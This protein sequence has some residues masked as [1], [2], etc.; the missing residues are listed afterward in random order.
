MAGWYSLCGT[1]CFALSTGSSLTWKAGKPV[2][3]AQVCG[4]LLHLLRAVLQ[5]WSSCVP[6]LTCGM[7]SSRNLPRPQNL[8]AWQPEWRWLNQA[9]RTPRTQ[10]INTLIQS[11]FWMA[12]TIPLTRTGGHHGD[13]MVALS[14]FGFVDQAAVV[15]CF[16]VWGWSRNMDHL[17][18][19]QIS[20]PYAYASRLVQEPPIWPGF[21]SMSVL[22]HSNHP[23]LWANNISCVTICIQL[24]VM[25][26]DIRV[27]TI[28]AGLS[29]SP[30]SLAVYPLDGCS[31]TLWS[32][33]AQ[34]F[35][36]M[37]LC[38]FGSKNIFSLTSGFHW[39]LSRFFEMNFCGSHL[40]FFRIILRYWRKAELVEWV[41]LF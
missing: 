39:Y 21:S 16:S 7:H 15:D 25:W 41:K 37:E 26:E 3:H 28:T 27:K 40:T 31:Q 18:C 29:C 11:P 4:D 5:V 24:G 23:K 6:F 2:H 13:T 32:Q 38:G 14:S 9:C 34:A 8:T 12:M 1:R 19:L 20:F 35:W 22:N 10:A 36:P 30:P 17:H 33:Q